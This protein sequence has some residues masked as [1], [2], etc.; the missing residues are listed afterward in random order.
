[1]FRGN[2]RTA[3]ARLHRL[4]ALACEC[5]PTETINLSSFNLAFHIETLNGHR[6]L[7]DTM[8]AELEAEQGAGI[9]TLPELSDADL[10]LLREFGIKG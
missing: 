6:D 9:S 2:R 8:V 1:M 3:I 7:T 10:R 5:M 4:A